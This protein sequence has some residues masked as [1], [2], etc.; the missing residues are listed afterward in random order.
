MLFSCNFK[1]NTTQTGKDS[2]LIEN[3]DTTVAVQV[4]PEE[5][6]GPD[7]FQKEYFVIMKNDTSSFSWV[8]TENKISGKM[9]MRY[10]YTPY[11]KIATSYS[12]KDTAAVAGYEPVKKFNHKSTYE[13]QI[14]EL[15]LILKYASKDYDLSKLSYMS[16]DMSSIN[17]LS[18]NI[19]EKY[20][21]QF[22]TINYLST[23][24]V[25]TLIK[26]SSFKTDLG[27]LLSPYSVII[28]ETFVDDGLI[29][30]IPRDSKTGSKAVL[31]CRVI[32]DLIPISR[33]D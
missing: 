6:S 3:S 18:Q 11:D 8:I 13:D 1:N 2:R 17:G 30:Y 28:K 12:L 10:R 20:V 24:K 25:T 27:N 31:H 14:R 23:Q 26:N 29:D 7:Y 15:K 19:L 33:L 22:G 9:S 5:I 16:I 21:N 32:F 4:L